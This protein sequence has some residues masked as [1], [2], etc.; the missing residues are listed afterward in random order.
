MGTSQIVLDGMVF[1][2]NP[3][4]SSFIIIKRNEKRYWTRSIGREDAETTLAKAM[5]LEID[6]GEK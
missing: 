6:G 1:A 5:R 2:V 3:D 4:S